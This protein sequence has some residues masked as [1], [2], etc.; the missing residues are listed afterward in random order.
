[1]FSTNI[2]FLF[3]NWEVIGI[4]SALL[5][6]YFYRRNQAVE[7]S[8]FAFSVYRICDAAFLFSGLLL[9][10][11][12]GSENILTK[13]DGIHAT[14]LGILIFIAIMGKS[15]IYPFSSWLPL[16]LEG[17]TPSSN[18]YYMT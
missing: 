11:F 14:V 5:I 4:S 16:A 17:P 12:S 8:L 7:N 2:D 6:S 10:A 9:F 13:M 3:F 1:I 15:G 18:L